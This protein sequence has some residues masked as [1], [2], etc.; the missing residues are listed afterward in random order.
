MSWLERSVLLL[1]AMLC[2]GFVAFGGVG[3][4]AAVEP[5]GD[6]TS[7]WVAWCIAG[8]IVAAP[9]WLPA[10]VPNRLPHAL[11]V[12][13]RVSAA[14]LVLP[15]CLFGSIV[16]HNLGRAVSSM[17]VASAA[18]AQGAVLSVACI[19]CLFILLRPGPG[20]DAPRGA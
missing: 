10:L 9:L 5:D 4:S 19:V 7:T 18:L 1:A 17:G 3:F 12:C 20:G 2:G 8:A 15:T 14:L 6:A 11:K 16:V 13:R